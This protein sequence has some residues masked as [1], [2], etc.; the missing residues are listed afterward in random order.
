MDLNCKKLFL[1]FFK[2]GAF[3]FG[4]GYAMI[5]L[6]KREIVEEKKW[7]SEQQMIDIIAI[8]ESTP[9]PLA[10]NAA[11]FVGRM[12]KGVKGA[13]VATLGVITPSFFLILLISQVLVKIENISIIQN[14]FMGIRVAVLVLISNAL[15]SLFKK[16]NHKVYTYFLFVL[17]LILSMILQLNAM[18]ILFICALLGVLWSLILG[19]MKKNDIF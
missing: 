19:K 7:L 1:T 11:T 6:I 15:F 4:G 17:A 12:V 8:S 16:M 9:G 10:I 18:L 14:A 2:I 3:T 13:L 5:P